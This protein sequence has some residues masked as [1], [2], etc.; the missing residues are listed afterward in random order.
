MKASTGDRTQALSLTTGTAGTTG[1]TKAQYFL[2]PAAEEETE[3]G[4]PQGAPI[5][6]HCVNTARSASFIFGP[7][8]IFNGPAVCRTAFINKLSAGFP[9]TIDGPRPP[10]LSACSRES[11][12]SPPIIGWLVAE[13]HPRHCAASNGRTRDSKNAEPSSCA[14]KGSTAKMKI[15][16][17]G[18]MCPILSILRANLNHYFP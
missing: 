13:W 11:N 15:N 1:G 5:C 12:R 18:A 3:T 9:G 10:P 14:A 2:D 16:T 7:G 8:G 6:T 4:A 17:Y